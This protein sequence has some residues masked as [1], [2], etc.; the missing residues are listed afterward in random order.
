[1]TPPLRARSCGSPIPTKWG[2]VNPLTS[3]QTANTSTAGRR[4]REDEGQIGGTADDRASRQAQSVTGL[5]P[6]AS[7]SCSGSKV[8]SP[9]ATPPSGVPLTVAVTPR[10]GMVAV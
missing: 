1:M 7:A 6:I 3:K 4:A 8:R 5:A 2:E 10:S 9:G